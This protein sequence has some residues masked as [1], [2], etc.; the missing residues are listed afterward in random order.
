M[1]F[2]FGICVFHRGSLLALNDGSFQTA[3]AKKGRIC[4]CPCFY[5][6]GIDEY[7]RNFGSLKAKSLAKVFSIASTL[8]AGPNPLVRGL[9]RNT[10]K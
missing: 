1:Y 3:Q 9:L 6:Y 7:L 4:F 2:T 10:W 5:F 8:P